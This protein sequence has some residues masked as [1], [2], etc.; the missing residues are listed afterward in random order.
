MIVSIRYYAKFFWRNFVRNKTHYLL[1]LLGLT[2]GISCFLFALLYVFYETSYDQYQFNRDRIARVVTTEVSGGYETHTALSNGFLASVLSKAFPEIEMMVRFKAFDGKAAI[3]V[4]AQNEEIPFDNI[5]YAD[6]EVFKMFSY[7]LLEGDRNSCLEEPNSVILSQ[8]MA[9]SLFGDS[10]AIDRVVRVNDKILKVTG[11]AADVPRNSDF[12]FNGLISMR[13]LSKPDA[14]P[15]LYTYILFKSIR[16]MADFQPRLDQFT[17]KFVDPKTVDQGIALSYKL[18]PFSSLHFSTSYVYDTPKGNKVSVDIFLVMGILIFIIACTNSINMMVVRSFSRSLEIGIQ[19]VYGAKRSELVLQHVLEALILAGTAVIFAFFFTGIFLS[20]F[21]AMVNRR[22]LFSDLFQWKILLA[23]LTGLLVIGMSVAVYVAFYLQQVRLGDVVRVRNSKGYGMKLVPK[24][25]LGF[26]F[27]ISIGMVVAALLV[28]RQVRYLRNLPLGFNPENILVVELPMGRQAEAGAKYLKGQLGT[29]PDVVKLSLCGSHSLP[30]EFTDI[31]VVEFR[32]NGVL[33]KRGVDNI[34]VDENY[35]TL[36]EVPILAGVGFEGRKS[37]SAEK[38][39]VIVTDLFSRK[40]GWRIPVGQTV[41]DEGDNE[42]VIG[43]VPDFHFSSLHNPIVPMVIFQDPSNPA[44]LLARV[45]DNKAGAVIDSM[46]R[47]WK[48]V[49][50]QFPL[51][52]FFLDQ[53]LQ[54]Q[55]KDE[56]N[57]FSILVSMSFLIICIS[58][59]GLIAYASYIIRIAIFDIAIRRVVGASFGNIFYLFNR[60]FLVLLSVGFVTACPLSLYFLG[61]WLSQYAYHTELMATD[62][63]IALGVMAFIVGIVVI[64]YTWQCTRVSPGKIIR[65]Q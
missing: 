39:Q 15:W 62:Y 7:P 16:A 52:Y 63:I 51:S 57:L 54:Q 53:H 3:K 59:I 17:R 20:K 26:Q 60:Q 27:F 55:Y 46:R 2:L 44:Y 9:K 1:N 4:S 25:M 24:L 48:T 40:A 45:R 41:T 42:Q 43:V 13:T 61:Q 33:V 28:S 29:D 18:E 36:L 50:N 65:Q 22:M 58:C 35:F 23:V 10:S 12:S 38:D 34:S 31:D 49:F 21:A 37:D 8:T 6:P 19:K 14:I 32:Q 5:Y 64:K 11:V 30:G 56:E 47:V